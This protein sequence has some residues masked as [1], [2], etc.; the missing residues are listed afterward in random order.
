MAIQVAQ[1][2]MT[3]AEAAAS[4][5]TNSTITASNGHHA[6]DQ[7]DPWAMLVDFD[8]NHADLILYLNDGKTAAGTGNRRRLVL[9]DLYCLPSHW[10][11]CYD[12]IQMS[13]G[14]LMPKV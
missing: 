10:Q 8:D 3:S 1:R 11:D 2:L 14:L 13:C 4:T 9:M 12:W 7:T 5:T 6:H